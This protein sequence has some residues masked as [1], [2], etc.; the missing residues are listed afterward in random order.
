MKSSAD[1]S[2]WPYIEM[3][4]DTLEWTNVIVADLALERRRES[5]IDCALEMVVTVLP[6]IAMSQATCR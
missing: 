4:H 1:M 5:K 6:L 3:S 2:G